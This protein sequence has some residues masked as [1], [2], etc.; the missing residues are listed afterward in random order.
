MFAREVGLSKHI[1]PL[2]VLVFNENN[3][4]NYRGSVRYGRQCRSACH[5][6]FK[7]GAWAYLTFVCLGTKWTSGYGTL[8]ILFITINVFANTKLATSFIGKMAR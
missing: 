8:L 1:G 5:T 3:P 7:R 6:T 4:Q 2:T